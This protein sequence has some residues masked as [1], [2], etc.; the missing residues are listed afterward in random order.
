MQS[1]IFT[2]YFATTSNFPIFLASCL[3][4]FY[5]PTYLI[6]VLWARIEDDNLSPSVAVVALE[7]AEVVCQVMISDHFGRYRPILEQSME[8]LT[9]C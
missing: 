4:L 3:Y 1:S 8:I 6:I 7:M 9:S 5:I 2:L